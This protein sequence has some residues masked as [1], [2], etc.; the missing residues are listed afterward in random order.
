MDGK[1]TVRTVR[2]RAE[3]KVEDPVMVAVYERNAFVPGFWVMWYGISLGLRW[4]WREIWR[5]G[6]RMK[7]SRFMQIG[8]SLNAA[9]RLRRIPTRGGPRRKPR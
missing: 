5:M 4:I 3:P 6:W 7:R 2:E 9:R 1:V 8:P